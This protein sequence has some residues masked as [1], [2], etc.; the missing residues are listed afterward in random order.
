MSDDSA[1]LRQ[2]PRVD[3]LLVHPRMAAVPAA[4]ALALKAAR[5]A[6]A[7]TRARL[8][9]GESA[10][11]ASADAVA[12]RAAE[13]LERAAAR[14]LR[15]AVNATGVL[16]HT[17]LGRAPLSDA[18]QRALADVAGG[19]CNVQADLGSGRRSEREDHVQGLFQA[20]TGAEA[21]LVVNNNAAAT[22]LALNTLAAGREVIVSRGEMVEI[23]GA[24]RIP[25][26]LKLAGCRLVE[27]GCTNRTHLRD[28]ERA[29][30]PETALIL[31]VH[32]SNYRIVGFAEQTPVRELAELAHARGI[33]CAHD[34][35]SGALLDLR[36]Y[37]LPHEPTA[38][39]SLAAGA[40]VTLFSGDKLLGGPQCGIL[41][42]KKA[43]LAAMHKNPFYRAFRVGKLT[44]AA[45]E[46]TL[47]LFLEPETLLE[48]HRLMSLLT[49]PLEGIRRRAESLA[50][51]IAASCAGWL[52]AEAQAGESEIG[53]GSLAGYP[54]PTVVVRLSPKG[55]SPDDLAARLRQSD[56]PIFT[57]V[58]EG[59]VLLDV[60]TM[61]PG[62]ERLIV[63][64]LKRIGAKV[65]Q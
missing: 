62:E 21:A 11:D 51:E 55:L 37:G 41:L 45:L 54:I 26:I 48:K 7:E 23:G 5:E 22:V 4:H 56:P 43:P 60:R 24:F 49:A 47:R 46:A 31:S 18:A 20:L 19:F 3:D 17:N 12:A 52:A 32:Q 38:P 57:R 39:E 35:G 8:L 29:L 65:Q 13:I 1:L 53:G 59:C 9:A 61:L 2:L 50:Q 40:D 34:L 16:L 64:A 30:T 58:H 44:L 15:R 10:V 33:P 6:V 14:S 42:G 27:V 28:Y 63:E 25:E 36:A